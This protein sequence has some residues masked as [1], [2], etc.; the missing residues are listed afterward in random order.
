MR[1]IFRSAFTLC[2]LHVMH[3]AGPW[4]TA[5][6]SDKRRICASFRRFASGPIPVLGTVLQ[7]VSRLPFAFSSATVSPRRK[8]QLKVSWW[9]ACVCARV[10]VRKKVN[11]DFALMLNIVQSFADQ[12][13]RFFLTRQIIVVLS[14]VCLTRQKTKYF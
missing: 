7:N 1:T 6:R 12:G 14:I 8:S 9:T 10:R 4:E 11:Q 5:L 2:A 13:V 3:P